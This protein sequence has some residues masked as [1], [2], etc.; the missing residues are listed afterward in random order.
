MGRL[1]NKNILFIIPKD[2]YCEEELEP[3]QEIFKKEEATVKIASSKFKEAIGMRRG[4]VMPDM[5]I[6]DAMEGITGDSYVTSAKGTRQI[7][8]V[9]HGVIIIGGSG[10]RR[11]L[12][13]EKLV[14]LLLSD[15]DRSHMII[16]AIGMGVPCL[17][18]AGLIQSMEVT[19]C[20]DKKALEAIDKAKAFVVEGNIKVNDNIITAKDASTVEEFAETVI[21]AVAKTKI[22]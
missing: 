22:K 10:T 4:R 20:D 6:V 15:R 13:D 2:Y 14:N 5:L 9:F 16:G 1:A 19:V 3:L 7:L 21:K 8:G 17:G 18:F 11:Y 12:W